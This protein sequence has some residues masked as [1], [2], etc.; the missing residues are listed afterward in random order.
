MRLLALRVV[1]ALFALTW[2]VFPGFGLIDLSVTWD[3]DWPVVLEAGWGVFMTVLVGGQFL[4]LA[5]RPHRAA[6]ALVTLTIALATLLVASGAG[7]EPWLFVYVAVLLVEGAAVVGL[8][9]RREPVRP[10]GLG[11][12]WPLLALAAAGAVPWLINAVHMF[13]DDRQRLGVLIGDVTNGV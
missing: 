5:V 11:P 13:E 12:S 9:P 2:L 10:M 6:P 1:A 8:L 7:G 3:P 4:A